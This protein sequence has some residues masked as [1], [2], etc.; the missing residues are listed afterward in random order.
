MIHVFVFNVIVILSQHFLEPQ[1]TSRDNDTRI[2]EQ[3]W[4]PLS[5][6]YCCVKIRLRIMIVLVLMISRRKQFQRCFFF[7]FDHL[8]RAGLITIN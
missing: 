3:L 5:C 1:I 4:Y 2:N 8:R 6:A 7:F